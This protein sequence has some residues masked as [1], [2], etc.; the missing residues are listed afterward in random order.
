MVAKYSFAPT[1]RETGLELLKPSQRNREQSCTD[2]ERANRWRI[3][4]RV[5]D[6]KGDANE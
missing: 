3:D 5:A 1:T 4:R 2:C 6:S